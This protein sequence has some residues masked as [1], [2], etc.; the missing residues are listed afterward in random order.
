MSIIELQPI[1]AK[2]ESITEMVFEAIRDGIVSKVLAPGSRISE[3]RLATQ[4]KVS[5]TPVREA[6]LQMRQL[7]LVEPIGRSLRVIRPSAGAIRDA[8]E[9]RAGL[10]RTA[11]ECAAAR[12]TAVE[13]DDI[14]VAAEA[15][16]NSA[17]SGDSLGFRRYDRD[18]HTAI[19]TA[20]QNLSLSRAVSDSLVLAS[21]LRQRD[22]SSSGDSVVCAEE[23]VQVARAL[24]TGNVKEAGAA[25]HAHIH[26]VMTL[27]LRELPESS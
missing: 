19:A 7:G 10:E 14:V 6:L 23:H 26:H 22:V 15:S 18:F 5:K 12:A 8:Y 24:R 27:V 21:A 9:M 1:M 16:L 17:L 4:L 2:S 11:A 20:S 13:R 25:L 3:A